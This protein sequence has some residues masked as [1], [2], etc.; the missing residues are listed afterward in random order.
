M[1][2]RGTSH[3]PQEQLATRRR[4]LQMAG[5]TA[6]G[7]ILTPRVWSSVSAQASEIALGALMP[8]SG[9]GGSFGQ[10]MLKAAQFAVE[11]I[12][13]AGG[14]LGRK[15]HLFQENDETNAEAAV[16]AAK[17]LIDINKVS[18]VFGT[19]ASSVTLAVA[20]LCQENKVVEMS[21]SG[22]SKITAIQKK[23]FVFRTE[24]DDLLFGRAYAECAIQYGWKT[25]AVLGLNVPFTASTVEAFRERF[26]AKGGKVLSITT[27]NENQTT[28]RSEVLKAFAS[29]P[30]FIHISGYDA[31]TES[32]LKVAYESGLKTKWLLPGFAVTDSVIK[33]AGPA[34]EGAY[35][36]EE[37]VAEDSPAYL[38]LAKR[39][40]GDRYYSYAAQTYDQ[41]NLLALAIE[42][43]KKADGAAINGKLREISGPPGEKVTSFAAGAALLRQGKKIDYDGASGPIDFNEDGN[44][45]KANFRISQIKQGKSTPV[46]LLKD[47]LF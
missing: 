13:G 20:P 8:L 4:L 11:E 35:L 45:A 14:P 7:L 33:N 32:I 6:A 46:G 25:A 21:T 23:G 12:N 43:A 15:I 1:T 39:L 16:R 30:D 17:K 19:W 22:S 5:G 28:F 36:I 44:I 40:G 18:A 2:R 38:R 29:K 26:E 10:D 42:A 41:A 47:V 9:S 24:P 37:G 27:Y 34:I 31:D 3:R